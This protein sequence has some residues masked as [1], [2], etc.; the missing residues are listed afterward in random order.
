VRDDVFL[1]ADRRTL[2]LLELNHVARRVVPVEHR[3][4]A[5]LPRP[6]ERLA[7]D[8]VD[9]E[10]DAIGL[11]QIEACCEPATKRCIA[12]T[13]GSAVSRTRGATIVL[14]ARFDPHS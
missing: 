1:P 10:L 14:P 8:R 2:T 6:I 12:A 11:Q 5:D 13:G 3:G 9:D 4:A 7:R